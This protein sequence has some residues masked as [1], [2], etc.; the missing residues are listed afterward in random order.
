MNILIRA[1]REAVEHKLEVNLLKEY[2]G[3]IP[4]S[5]FCY[6]TGIYP[7]HWELGDKV[8]FTDGNVVFAEGK[9]LDTGIIDGK[10]A[11]CFEPLKEVNYIQ[12]KNAP[13]R[14]FTY[15]K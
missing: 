9:V 3:D 1:T 13:T 12:P 7:I 5:L 15:V 11:L 14:G 6:W 2:N 4:E 10:R 8:M